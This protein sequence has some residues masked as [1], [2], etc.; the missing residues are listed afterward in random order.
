MRKREK[1]EKDCFKRVVFNIT[2][3]MHSA[4]ERRRRRRRCRREQ[5]NNVVKFFCERAAFTTE[6]KQTSSN[7]GSKSFAKDYLFNLF[8][9]HP[10][11][12]FSF[13]YDY[14]LAK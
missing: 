5:Q 14:I 13:N 1:P 8:C 7:I 9:F 12:L 3:C 6:V 4:R 2:A 10:H 11:E